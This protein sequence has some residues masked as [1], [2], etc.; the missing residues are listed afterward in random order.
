MLKMVKVEYRARINVYLYDFS[1]SYQDRWQMSVLQFVQIKSKSIEFCEY[2]WPSAFSA[3]TGFTARS[4]YAA[5]VSRVCWRA[6]SH[7]FEEESR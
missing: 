3:T 5:A 1:A 7:V 2:H 4:G 6:S